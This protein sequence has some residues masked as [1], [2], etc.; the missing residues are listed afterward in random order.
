MQTLYIDNKLEGGFKDYSRHLM[1]A[2]QFYSHEN[3]QPALFKFRLQDISDPDF[4]IP[5]RGSYV[6]FEDNRFESRD[7][8]V[9][10]GLLFS[11]YVSDDPAPIYLGDNNNNA[12]IAYDITATTEDYLPQI[13]QLPNKIY[14]NKTRGYIIRDVIAIMFLGA[15]E[16][17][18]D[19]SGVR[20]GGVERLYQTDPT[21]KF[22]DMASEFAKADAYRYRVLGGKIFYG[23]EV[24]ILPGSSDPQVKL[25]IDGEDPRYTP[26]NIN[27]E[28]VATSIVND[29]TVF[30][31]EEPTTFVHEHWVS[32]GYEGAHRLLYKPYGVEEK[33]LI[34]DDFT[35]PDFET[36]LW[37]E[38]DDDQA[39]TGAGDGS[40]IQMFDG[41]LNIVGGAGTQEAPEAYLRSRRGIE[42]SGI[43]EF[44][45]CELYFAP[46][47]PAGV[48]FL[49]GLYTDE[50]M[51][52]SSCLSCWFVDLPD[53]FVTHI[54]N[55]VQ[56]T[57][58]ILCPLNPD[59]NHHYV[60][61]RHFEFDIPV[62]NP[63]VR[64]GPRGTDVVFGDDAAQVNGCQVTYTVD[65]IDITDPQNV[66]TSRMT[67]GSFRIEN[68][69]DFVLYSP[70]VSLSLHAVMNY[71][72]V[73]R[74]QQVRVTVNG[75][76][77]PIGDYIDGGMATV[78]L[79]ETKSSL[80]WYAIAPSVQ[81][82]DTPTTPTV[83]G[84]PYA[85]WKLGDPTTYI[86]DSGDSRTF[87]MTAASLV[88]L[89]PGAPTSSVDQARS[90]PGNL[91]A[92]SGFPFGASI[93]GP[94]TGSSTFFAHSSTGG[95]PVP[96]S[97]SG[98]INTT[99]TDGP[100]FT[101]PGFAA[102]RYVGV[103]VQNGRITSR[104][105]TPENAI[106]SNAVINNG[107]WHHFVVVNDGSTTTIYVDGVLDASGAQTL[108]DTTAGGYPSG[109]AIGYDNVA[110]GSLGGAFIQSWFAGAIDEIA[111]WGEA[112]TQDMVNSLFTSSQ[113]PT[114]STGGGGSG[115]P[116]PNYNPQTGVTIPPQGALIDIYY[117]RSDK[118]RA[119]VK[120]TESILLERAKFGDDGLRQ[121]TVLPEDV[122]PPPRTSAECQFLAQAFLADRATPRYE[123]S[124]TFET[125]ENDITR[126][127]IMP[128][129]GDM[130]P[131]RMDLGREI[132]D[133][134][135]HCT[136]ISSSFMGK[137]AY[138][139][140]LSVGPLNRFNEA[141]RKLLVARRSS[142]DNPEI[143]DRD[144]LIAEVLNSTGYSIPADPQESEITSITPYTFTVNMNPVG[145]VS[146]YAT[147]GGDA[148][149]NALPDGVVGYEVRRDDSGWG[150]NNYVARVSTSVF[151]LNRGQRDRAYFIRPFNL[152]NV[153]SR[154]SA[155]VRVISPLSNTLT[156]DKLDGDISATSVRL[157]I[158]IDRNPDIGG[159][160][161]QKDNA[162]GPALYH[163]NGIDHRYIVSGATVLVESGSVSISFPLSL[164]VS[165]VRVLVYN[166]LGEYGPPSTFTITRP[167]P[168]V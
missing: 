7:E 16:S 144:T 137:G 97:I 73:H 122:F 160:L 165:T 60:L 129:P 49:G 154:Q 111:L 167:A 123:G 114:T 91:G 32:D 141:Q 26:D 136:N 17:P 168:E 149:N 104:L 110:W 166:L 30:G 4:V 128:V 143:A 108:S 42:L 38:I 132:I 102:G 67:L 106:S 14:V 115:T 21:K 19:T 161:V 135:M 15:D 162:D 118:S 124:Y 87:P 98:W 163:G 120:S 76:S 57:D 127:D 86:A 27:I 145:S 164:G 10:D 158:P 95:F 8:G 152:Q 92:T 78:V 74:P 138:S 33:V 101:T 65:I 155:L 85:F 51:S 9:P 126:L 93:I 109:W 24:E 156:A 61:R 105:S 31:E 58:Q 79:E 37:E 117:Y 157:Y 107:G 112:V 28:R 68:V 6:T 5:T 142:L 81:N 69:P 56:R 90:F 134:D 20:D 71:C 66:V 72:K 46:G 34:E 70:V 153:Y 75:R 55:G 159:W 147:N 100:I 131:C 25:I 1:D 13:K 43:I 41:A 44:R 12:V 151:T 22:A 2:N 52:L 54:T 62:G 113:D 84:V 29:V 59:G 99:A 35:S 80:S 89:T 150:Q 50:S 53:G 96:Y 47:S 82:P 88:T 139:I 36:T 119:R 64:R 140:T 83:S 133:T 45:D 23:P 125:G 77:I 3:N 48:G 146:D 39:L 18:L 63:V 40:Y 130:I 116:P 121:Q 11:G 103:W 148:I 94:I